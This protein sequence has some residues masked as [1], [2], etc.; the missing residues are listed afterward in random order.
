MW[1]VTGFIWGEKEVE[2]DRKFTNKTIYIYIYYVYIY[3]YI[4]VC[5]CVYVYMFVNLMYSSDTILRAHVLLHIGS[6]HLD[7]AFITW[8][9]TLRF[10]KLPKTL[11]CLSSLCGD[12][13]WRVWVPY[14]EINADVSEFLT[15]RSTLTC[16][17]FLCGDQRW[18]VWVPYVEINAD[19]SEF[20]HHLWFQPF[21]QRKYFDEPSI[22]I[23]SHV[24]RKVWNNAC[25]HVCICCMYTCIHT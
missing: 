6:L 20:S 22:Q 12:Q 14:V 15:Y 3:I 25:M 2:K 10:D 8:R 19:V 9:S 1:H 18:R 16:L 21:V 4:C 11:T 7:L 24:C 23:Q 13:R 5:V 17:S